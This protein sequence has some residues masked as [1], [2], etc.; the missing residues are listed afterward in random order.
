MQI[1]VFAVG[2]MKKGPEQELANRY[3]ER[4]SKLAPSLGLN[5]LNVHEI[6][7]SRL[8]NANQRMEEEGAKLIESLPDNSRLIVLDERGKSVSSVIFSE[9]FQNWRDAGTKHITVALGGP[10]GHCKKVR[11]RADLLLS[12][13]AMTWPH[14]IARILLSEQLYRMAT[15]LS[16]HPYH[17]V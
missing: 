4:F 14:Q 11:E 1:S 15:I 9:S 16:G 5:F 13:G 10:D 17:R 7:E 3:F 12:F 2:R 6:T 8:Q